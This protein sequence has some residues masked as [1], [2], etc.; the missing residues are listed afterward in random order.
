V[1][2][3]DNDDEEATTLRETVPQNLARSAS[4]GNIWVP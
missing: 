1:F 4:Q 3:D 2:V